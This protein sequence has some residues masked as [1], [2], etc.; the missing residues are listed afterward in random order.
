MKKPIVAAFL[1]IYFLVSP[2]AIADSMLETARDA[3]ILLATKDESGRS[4]FGSG[5]LISE[6]GYLVTNYHI[7]HR[8]TEMMIWF[9][10]EEDPKAYTAELI[11][12]DGVAD[13]ALLKMTVKPDMLPLT[14]LEIESES[15]EVG[16]RVFVIG[17]LLG[18]DWT[19]T[20]GIISHVNRTT[21]IS[22]LVRLLQIDAAVNRGNSG[23]PIVNE[24]GKVVGV[25]TTTRFDEKGLT[26]GV[27]N[28]VRG[29]YLNAIVLDLMDDGKIERP[30][31]QE[32]F[33]HM[34]P[35]NV[36]KLRKEYPGLLFPD[37]F[38]L[39]AVEIKEDAYSYSQ[40]LR[41]FDIVIG[42]DG[43]AI[44]NMHELSDIIGK[45]NIGDTMNLTIIRE[46]VT[47]NLPYVLK[48]LEFDHVAHF[49]ERMK[50]LTESEDKKEEGE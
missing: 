28:G 23:G 7:V 3:V 24:D 27:G 39:L 25:I 17:H 11:G 10:D 2:Y 47:M 13:I 42:A 44:D 41:D 50:R 9:Y 45:K 35:W 8:Q 12:V 26:V 33:K 21:R 32:K 22:S 6:D 40:G 29:D 43:V 1:F 37:V 18:L 38:G 36:D 19:I 49:D 46:G 20:S 5:F 48:N 34:S 30:A 4:G 14:H 16:D 15:I 31:M